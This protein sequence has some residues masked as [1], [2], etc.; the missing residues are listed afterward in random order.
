MI[1][2]IVDVVVVVVVVVLFLTTII[3]YRSIH[4]EDL[5]FFSLFVLVLILDI[6]Y[7]LLFLIFLRFLFV[8]SLLFRVNAVLQSSIVR[9]R[10]NQSTRTTTPSTDDNSF[11]ILLPVAPSFALLLP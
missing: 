4:S 11:R 1:I 10:R 6:E 5:F 8:L 2:I 3:V 7:L 9:L